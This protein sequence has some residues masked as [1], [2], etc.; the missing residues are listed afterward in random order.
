MMDERI[1]SHPKMVQL[2]WEQHD[3]K[4]ALSAR[5]AQRFVSLALVLDRELRKVD[6]ARVDE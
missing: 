6:T 1:R 3:E 4:V 2:L 5:H